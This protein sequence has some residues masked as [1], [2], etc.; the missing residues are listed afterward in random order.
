MYHV[1]QHQSSFSFGSWS[2]RHT[3]KK[4]FEEMF[5]S[6][7]HVC[8]QL[9]LSSVSCFIVFDKHQST[10]QSYTRP[11]GL[12]SLLLSSPWKG[13]RGTYV[14]ICIYVKTK[15]CIYTRIQTHVFLF[16]IYRPKRMR[17]KCV[18][19]CKHTSTYTWVTFCRAEDAFTTA[20]AFAL[21]IWK[22]F[23]KIG[24]VFFPQNSSQHILHTCLSLCVWEWWSM[25]VC[26]RSAVMIVIKQHV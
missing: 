22:S 8:S 25:L 23:G 6:W 12:S 17:E 13:W 3:V 2:F 11:F 5:C 4:W 26:L 20:F 16:S 7:L 19:I 21:V 9:C 10:K 14:Y 24:R 18:Y 15:M 1:V